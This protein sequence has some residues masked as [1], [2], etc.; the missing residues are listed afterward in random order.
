MSI[1][2]AILAYDYKAWYQTI[3][4]ISISNKNLSRQ[5]WN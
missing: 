3:E 4:S 1:E 5:N 2:D